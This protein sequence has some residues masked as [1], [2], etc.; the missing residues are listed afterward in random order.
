[1]L[2][3][4]VIALFC[5]GLFCAGIASAASIHIDLTRGS[6]LNNR[7]GVRG[8][9]PAVRVTGDDG[10]PVAGALVIFTAPSAGPSIDFGNGA[11]AQT[12]TDDSG[13]A[14]APAP[15]PIG[16]N[17]PVMVAVL[18]EKDGAVANAVIC[19]MNLGFSPADASGDM[20]ISLIPDGKPP[21]GSAGKRILR[22]RVTDGTGTAVAGANLSLRI[23]PNKNSV[24]EVVSLTHTDG[25]G[26]FQV[27]AKLLKG[28][29]EIPVTATAH[30]VTATRMI[31]IDKE[32]P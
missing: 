12:S 19:E 17:G 4:C 8:Q 26:D 5:S 10:K 20:E 30:G 1:M 22:V 3:R 29:A 27:D 7:V 31:A 21:Q 15:R 25:V 24:Q 11:T 18:A 14:S 6:G 13:T 9:S 28:L 23:Y 32:V 2:T 16:G